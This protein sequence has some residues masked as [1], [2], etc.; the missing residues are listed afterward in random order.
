MRAE[1]L[2]SRERHDVAFSHRKIGSRTGAVPARPGVRVFQRA[3]VADRDWHADGAFRRATRG[4]SLPS[5]PGLLVRV[6]ADAGADRLDGAPPALWLQG[7]DARGVEDAQLLSGCAG[8]AGR[9]GDLGWGTVVDGAG[10]RVERILLLRLPLDRRGGEHRVVLR[11]A[12]GESART[13]FCER[14]IRLG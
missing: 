2:R 1:G 4:N 12:A 3:R 14:S 9:A 11:A 13:L 5:G 6:R 10:S 8:L 7:A